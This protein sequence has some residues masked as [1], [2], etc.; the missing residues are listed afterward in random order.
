MKRKLDEAIEPPSK[1]QRQDEEEVTSWNIVNKRISKCF[2]N[3]IGVIIKD[4]LSSIISDN[5]I[6]NN[7]IEYITPQYELRPYWEPILKQ[8][9]LITDKNSLWTESKFGGKPFL[10]ENE[11]WPRCEYNKQDCNYYMPLLIQ[12]NMNKL[13]KEYINN[14]K[15]IKNYNKY[16]KGHLLQ[17]FY[18][19]DGAN[20][21]GAM[22]YGQPFG[23]MHYQRMIKITSNTKH[24]DNEYCNKIINEM[25]ENDLESFTGEQVEI[26]GWKKA[27]RIE[28]ASYGLDD[29][30]KSYFGIDISYGNR[31]KLDDIFGDGISEFIDEMENCEDEGNKLYGH[32]A[33]YYNNYPK[34]EIKDCDEEMSV[35]ICQVSPCEVNGFYLGDG[36]TCGQLLACPVHP[37]CIA[38][39]WCAA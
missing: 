17:L 27:E 22:E 39:H 6:I 3:K 7:I 23:K 28:G 26:I 2:K 24:K 25:K 14:S 21:A 5:N 16:Y 37:Y 12:L 31:N 19:G 15:Y 13:P 33:F 35:M 20:C 30:I 9:E 18:C 1:R 36:S 8:K 4:N 32:P 10:F 29:D 38:F 11:E 34:C